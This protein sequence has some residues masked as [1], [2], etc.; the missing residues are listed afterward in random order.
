MPGLG[1]P[2]LKAGHDDTD[3]EDLRKEQTT[4]V[5]LT[6][7]VLSFIG[8]QLT[9]FVPSPSRSLSTAMAILL[10]LFLQSVIMYS[11]RTH[12]PTLARVGLVLGPTIGLALA[13]SQIRD[14][15]IPC[16]GVLMVILSTSI[17]AFWGLLSV[18][19][20]TVVFL[21]VLGLNSGAMLVLALIGVSAAVEWLSSW[22]FHTVLSWSQSSQQKASALLEELRQRQGDLNKA[23]T[24]LTEATRRLERTNYELAIARQQADEAR[25]IK[26]QFV[27]NVS[28]E[29]RTPLNIIV[30]F[31]EMIYLSPA[32][33]GDVN[34]TPALQG[35]LHEIYRASRHLQSLI[36][37]VL[38]LSC[39]EASHLSISR[40]PL[41]V[42]TVIA[43]S[44]EIMSSL[45]ERR[46]LYYRVE[47]PV[48]LR[49]LYADRTRVRQV[50]LN[51]LGNAIRFT[52]RGGITIRARETS[53]V[54]EI[55]VHDTGIGIAKGQLEHIFEEF[56]QA[57]PGLN[58]RGGTGLGLTLSRKFVELHGGRMWV[59]SELG[60]GSSFYFTL[61]LPGAVS[62][63]APLRRIPSRTHLARRRA[64][65]L[66]LDRDPAVADMLNRYLGDR[67]VLVVRDATEARA[68][69]ESLHPAGI[70]VNQPPD[71]P[72]DCRPGEL[73]EDCSVLGVPVWHCTIPSAGWL[74][75]GKGIDE[76]LVKPVSTESLGRVVTQYCPPGGTV[77]VV[78]D[79]AAFVRLIVRMLEKMGN[80]RQVLRA[81]SGSQALRVA[82]DQ[83]PDLVLL[84]IL[85]PEMDGFAVTRAMRECP[86]LADT[87]IVALSATGY[88]EEARACL[89][90]RFS[91]TQPQ[92]LTPLVLSK[93]LSAGLD[94]VQPNYLPADRT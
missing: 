77:L 36:N 75:S 50:L 91:L 88:E 26:E 15:L 87:A 9:M 62:P 7:L 57:Q 73:G 46:E 20:C 11:I 4:V 41:D 43:D 81:Y 67:P 27:A 10:A 6:Y 64:P 30:G 92:G 22:R 35:D 17:S 58:S 55:C 19:S 53:D 66:L 83:V 94:I 52:D 48:G 13:L 31:S 49:P 23:L 89:G 42:H 82:T 59:E 60:V 45:L 65:V 54:I 47:C 16:L 39:I 28:H 29:L 63:A 37:D 40:E 25:S 5:A 33:Y 51:L 12:H 2:S 86:A 21:A 72:V 78:D 14:P 85:M 56:R 68:M 34:W 61:P 76:S 44:V 90:T 8:L 74:P 84:D 32:L 71:A 70:I 79:D 80:A 93:L 69:V 3:I 1:N 38:D 24:S 18:I